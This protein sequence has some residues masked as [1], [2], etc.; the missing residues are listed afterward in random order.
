MGFRPRDRVPGLDSTEP[1][2]QIPRV[3]RIGRGPS[4]ACESRG[5]RAL[6][7]N[8]LG[9]NAPRTRQRLGVPMLRRVADQRRLRAVRPDVGERRRFGRSQRAVNQPRAAAVRAA[10]RLGR[11]QRRC[12][13]AEQRGGRVDSQQQTPAHGQPRLTLGIRQEP[14]VPNL[15]ETLGQHVLHEAAQELRIGELIRS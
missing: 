8:L 13:D 15:H 1:V 7:S 12:L 5:L 4:A 14:V 10:G 2:G 9:R 11:C 3:F 6:A